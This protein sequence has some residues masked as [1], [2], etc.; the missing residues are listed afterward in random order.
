MKKAFLMLCLAVPA[1]A[2]TLH[3]RAP[4]K[5]L[6]RTAHNRTPT[7]HSRYNDMLKPKTGLFSGRIGHRTTNK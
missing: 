7:D 3:E 2:A 6:D 4:H 5:A 1:P